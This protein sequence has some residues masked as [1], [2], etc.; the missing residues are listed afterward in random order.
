MVNSMLYPPIREHIGRDRRL[1]A[2]VPVSGMSGLIALLVLAQSVAAQSVAVQKVDFD[3][4]IRPLLV[5]HCLE[6]HRGPESK[7]GLDLS[8]PQLFARGGDSGQVIVPGSASESLLWER[9]SEDEMPPKHSLGKSQKRTL[10][11]WIDQGASWSGGPL[12][13]FSITTDSRAGRD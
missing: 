8:D 1:S 6:C 11:N 13:M 10:R 4:E 5:S 2:A 9:V 7:G 3:K 12:D